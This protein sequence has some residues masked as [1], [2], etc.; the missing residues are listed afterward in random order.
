MMTLERFA[1]LDAEP[2]DEAWLMHNTKVTGPFGKAD[3]SRIRRVLKGD[4]R[5]YP[6]V[7]GPQ[8][9]FIS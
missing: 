5:I 3:L 1:D 7:F 4:I 6:I 9:E 2:Y 8:P